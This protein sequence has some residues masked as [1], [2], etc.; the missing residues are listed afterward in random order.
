MADEFVFDFDKITITEY[1]RLFEKETPQS[2]EDETV[3]KTLGISGDELRKFSQAKYRRLVKAFF[4]A[5]TAPVEE[6][7]T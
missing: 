1:R 2:E 3:A 4:K 6:N 7:P 5:A